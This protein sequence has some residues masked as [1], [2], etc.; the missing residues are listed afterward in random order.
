VTINKFQKNICRIH[1]T[2]VRKNFAAQEKFFAAQ[3]KIFAAQEKSLYFL[4][5]IIG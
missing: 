4:T 5:M 2:A 1:H 3:E